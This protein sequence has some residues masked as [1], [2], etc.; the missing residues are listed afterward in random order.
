VAAA[1]AHRQRKCLTVLASAAVQQTVFV[2]ADEATK[3]IQHAESVHCPKR[4]CF[5]YRC[6]M[7][8]DK[9]DIVHVHVALFSRLSGLWRVAQ[10]RSVTEL[11]LAPLN[12][13]KLD[14][15]R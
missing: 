6:A 11:K 7:D 10:P 12:L 14:N 2:A 3:H 5:S 1:A 15:A 4:R 8:R 9:I 13:Y